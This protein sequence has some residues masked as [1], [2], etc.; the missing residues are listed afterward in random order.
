MISETLQKWY[1]NENHHSQR[2]A[3]VGH[4]Q[5]IL[6]LRKHQTPSAYLDHN[7][8]DENVYKKSQTALKQHIHMVGIR[9]DRANH[10]GKISDILTSER[11]MH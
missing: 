2:S 3:A 4:P 8:V 5:F 1:R 9:R 10:F 11:W 7:M 6:G